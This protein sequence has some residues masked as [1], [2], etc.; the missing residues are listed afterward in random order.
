MLKVLK[1]KKA[2]INDLTTENL[3][4]LEKQAS[5]HKK[6]ISELM[7]KHDDALKDKE[8]ELEKR[9]EKKFKEQEIEYER[10]LNVEKQEFQR[11]L[12]ILENEKT[13]KVNEYEKLCKKQIEINNRLSDKEQFFEILFMRSDVLREGVKE[14]KKQL[15]MDYGQI[16]RLLDDMDNLRISYNKGI[17]TKEVMPAI[18]VTTEKKI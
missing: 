6:E 14:K 1:S 17:V 13:N 15:D 2:L 5:K 8:T 7:E 16:L 18:S 9:W 3:T 4:N 11:R 10:R 12:V